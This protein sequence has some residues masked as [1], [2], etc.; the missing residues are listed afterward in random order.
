MLYSRLQDLSKE[1]HRLESTQVTDQQPQDGILSNCCLLSTPS[2]TLTGITSYLDPPSLFCL[3][4]VNTTLSHHVKDDNT[5][6]RAFATYYLGMGPHDDWYDGA[7]VILLRRSK[8]SWRDE[9]IARFK[10]ERCVVRG[11]RFF[12]I[13]TINFPESGKTP[14]AHPFP[15]SPSPLLYLLSI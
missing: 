10:L 12:V 9:F 6:R 4:R 7:K 5:W 11:D 8:K 3:A 15:M 14:A 2:E 13:L 1:S